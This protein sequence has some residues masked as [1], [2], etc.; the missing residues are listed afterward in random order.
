MKKNNFKNNKNRKKREDKINILDDPNIII[1]KNAV[2]EYL[3][4]GKDIKK[5]EIEDT[6][7]KDK[8][9]KLIKE[10]LKENK[11]VSKEEENKILEKV[12]IIS[13]KDIEKYG[14]RHQGLV[15]TTKDFKYKSLD[16]IF[17]DLDIKEEKPLIV[18]LDKIEDPNNLG[19]ILRTSEIFGVS[20][21]VIP[22]HGSAK[23]TPVVRKVSVGGSEIVPVVLT[24]NINYLIDDL[25]EKGFWIYVADMEGA[26]NIYDLEYDSPTA[27]VFG[28]EGKG[29]SRLTREKSDFIFKIPMIGTLDSL[30]VSVSA[31]ISIYEVQKRRGKI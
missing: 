21:V 26:E 10:K 1:G 3:K 20:A 24:N 27:L 7:G 6:E 8:I 28:N 16:E 12:E 14:S 4:I 23:V 11:N 25:K 31:G 9:I 15:L 22:I 13:K 18:I 29:V 19:S 30:N 5:I 17:K 2:L